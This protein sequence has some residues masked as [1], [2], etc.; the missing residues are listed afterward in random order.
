MLKFKQLLDD[1]QKEQINYKKALEE[2]ERV[3]DILRQENKEL[4]EKHQLEENNLKEK[5][6]ELK[7]KSSTILGNKENCL[8]ILRNL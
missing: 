7:I 1:H 4:I 6:K 3:K 8:K 2:K 5:Y